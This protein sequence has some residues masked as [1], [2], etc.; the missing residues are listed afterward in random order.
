MIGNSRTRRE[1]QT[2]HCR[3][4]QVVHLAHGISHPHF[5]LIIFTVSVTLKYSLLIANE[6]IFFVSIGLL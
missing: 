6:Q 4:C 2:R 5:H 3:Y 1:L